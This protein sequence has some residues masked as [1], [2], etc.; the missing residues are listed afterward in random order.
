MAWAVFSARAMQPANP[1]TAQVV[2]ALNVGLGAS[3]V[4]VLL[5]GVAVVTSLAARWR[6][7]VHGELHRSRRADIWPPM[8]L[9]TNRRRENLA[10]PIT[11]TALFVGILIGPPCTFF[12]LEILDLPDPVRVA[13]ALAVVFGYPLF[14]AV[15]FFVLR[16][17]VFADSAWECWPESIQ[18]VQ[19]EQHG[20]SALSLP[21]N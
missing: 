19:L 17:K 20:L 10:R 14:G 8:L 15:S 2:S 4:L 6:V 3:T 21:V 11:M 5:V 1:I 13:S 9:T 16:S 12:L 18:Q 7:W